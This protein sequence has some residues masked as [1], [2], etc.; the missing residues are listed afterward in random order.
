[1]TADKQCADVPDWAACNVRDGGQAFEVC[2]QGKSHGEVSWQL[3]GLHNVSNGLAAIS[4][5]RHA[6]VPVAM[7][8]KALGEFIGVSR[9]MQLLANQ[10]G[11][12]VYDDF[13]HHPTAIASTLHGMRA[14]HPRGRLIAVVEPR[15][16]TMK[17]GVHKDKLAAALRDADRVYV[18]AGESLGWDPAAALEVLG[19]KLLIR[20]DT[21]LILS[22]VLA[23]LRPG[24]DV[25]IMSNGGFEGLPAR[26]ARAVEALVP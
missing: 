7:S 25:V 22:E 26:L 3:G 14:S 21:A 9:R 15:S 20:T 5:A 2:C 17:M 4:A 11:V 6:G 19:N 24:D 18:Y 10:N 1:M 16:N 12:R 8:L 13:A 23:E